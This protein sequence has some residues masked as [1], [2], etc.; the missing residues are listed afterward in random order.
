MTLEIDTAWS[1]LIDWMRMRLCQKA[2]SIQL[3]LKWFWPHTIRVP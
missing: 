1:R 2:Q 3:D